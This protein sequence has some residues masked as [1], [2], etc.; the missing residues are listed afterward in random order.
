MR[1]ITTGNFS[2]SAAAACVV[3]ALCSN[4][5][6]SESLSGIAPTAGAWM[7]DVS[8][9]VQELRERTREAAARARER[10]EQAT[11]TER[12]RYVAARPL[13]AVPR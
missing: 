12:W 13:L 4:A 7:P 10:S 6:A 11:A 8:Q 1:T 9:R 2:R 5:T 3:L